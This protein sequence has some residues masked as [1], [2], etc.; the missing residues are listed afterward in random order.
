MTLRELHDAIDEMHRQD[1]IRWTE[2]LEM[3]E[4]A[5]LD[6]FAEVFEGRAYVTDD[7]TGRVW[8]E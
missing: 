8:P 2:T 7:E 6:A 4:K 3:L 1:T 5:I